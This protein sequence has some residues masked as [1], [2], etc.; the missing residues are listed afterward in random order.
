MSDTLAHQAAR[1]WGFDPAHVTLAARRENIV[2]R[3]DGPDGAFALRLHRPGYRTRAQLQSELHWMTALERG[4]MAVPRPLP[5][6]D[7]AMTARLGDTLVD[8]LSWLPGQ[9][10]GAQGALD[11]VSDRPALAHRLGR[12]LAQMHD[13]SDTW[14]PPADFTRPAWDRA[15]LLGD[16]P[17]WG[18][19]WDHPDLTADQRSTFTAA[20]ARADADLAALE[21]GLDYGLIH[22]DVITENVMRDGDA[23]YLIDF[24][25]GGWG[26]RDFE[27]A[28]FLMRFLTAPDYS[29]IRAALVDGYAMRRR[30]DART[31][32]LFL[33][34]RALTYPGWIIPRLHE[35]GGAERSARAIATAIPLAE[36]YLNGGK[37]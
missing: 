4:G 6:P 1:L 33:L 29:E 34:L 14:T 15:G 30:V 8:V 2:Y 32:D 31:L 22:A 18:R 3:V 5:L 21:T 19:F 17:L 16:A 35:P 9:P 26:F 24:D 13:L 7:G 11:G 37:A 20:R 23:L 10:L 12:L 25:D 27:L 36:R 28:T